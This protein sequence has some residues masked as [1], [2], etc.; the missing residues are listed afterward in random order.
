MLAAV[1]LFHQQLD[2]HFMQL[3]VGGQRSMRVFGEENHELTP[4]QR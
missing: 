4:G 1:D 2:D 3:S